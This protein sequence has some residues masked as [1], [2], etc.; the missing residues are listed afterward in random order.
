MAS[1]CLKWMNR[2]ITHEQPDEYSKSWTPNSILANVDLSILLSGSM[3]AESKS[4]QFSFSI[5]AHSEKVAS[6]GT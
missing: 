1:K 2:A 5:N 3:A 4:D 6:S